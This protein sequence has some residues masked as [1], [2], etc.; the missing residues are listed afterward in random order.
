MEAELTL[1]HILGKED[2]IKLAKAKWRQWR[3]QAMSLQIMNENYFLL[4]CA[5]PLMHTSAKG[6]LSEKTQNTDILLQWIKKSAVLKKIHHCTVLVHATMLLVT[7]YPLRAVAHLQTYLQICE[8]C[9]VHKYWLSK[10]GNFI[11]LYTLGIWGDI[12]NCPQFFIQTS[13][14]TIRIHY[15]SKDPVGFPPTPSSR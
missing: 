13:N 6:S 2:W 9:D 3:V 8:W 1:G 4:S 5:P 15:H 14:S 11:L 10:L 12:L 7:T